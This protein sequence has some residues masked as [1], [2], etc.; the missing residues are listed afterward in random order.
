[1]WPSPSGRD[2]LLAEAD[3]IAALAI[4]FLLAASDGAG[5]GTRAERP[6]PIEEEAVEEEVE[7]AGRPDTCGAADGEP[8]LETTAFTGSCG[9]RNAALPERGRGRRLV[10]TPPAPL[11]VFSLSFP[12]LF[13]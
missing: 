8:L 1:M 6:L 3:F 2:R 13:A 12:L 4:I 10:S 5:G 11:S 7:A 9:L